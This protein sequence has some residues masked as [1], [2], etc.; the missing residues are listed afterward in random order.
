MGAG[1]YAEFQQLSKLSLSDNV[2][3]NID[4]TAFC[5]TQ[6]ED[7]NLSDNLHSG[8]PDLCC[9]AGTLR[10]LTLSYN[11]LYVLHGLG[12]L[13]VLS[14]LDVSWNLMSIIDVDLL[15]PSLAKL[16]VSGNPLSSIESTS[17]DTTQNIE[18]LIA[19]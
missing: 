2:I 16:V 10:R 13:N 17:N 8:V 9:I 19:Q 15:P 3:T 5:G 18:C 12:C 11:D 4:D 14:F 7:L 1:E 6:I